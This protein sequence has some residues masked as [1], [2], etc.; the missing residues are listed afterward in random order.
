MKVFVYGSLKRGHYNHYLIK[1]QKFLREA[2][3]KKEFSLYDLG[4]FPAMV[5][6]GSSSIVGEVY[7]VDKRALKVLDRL[8]SHPHFY[9]RK[10]IQLD[11]GEKVLTYL[12]ND[13]YIPASKSKIIKN[14]KW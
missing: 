11:N 13:E 6:N 2:K 9:R 5:E 10:E 3:T 4:S 8:E 14:G 12:L 1:D 7:Q